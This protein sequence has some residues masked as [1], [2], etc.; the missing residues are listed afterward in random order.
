MTPKWGPR[1]SPERSRK[2]CLKKHGKVKL[3]NYTLCFVHVGHP[4][5]S[6]I[7]ESLWHQKS[8]KTTSK[9][10][11]VKKHQQ[12]RQKVKQN[13]PKEN[14]GTRLVSPFSCR[15]APFRSRWVSVVPFG[16]SGRSKTPKWPPK[17]SPGHP[18]ST[19]NTKSYPTRRHTHTQTSLNN[20]IALVP[21]CCF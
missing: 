19:K 9:N 17:W 3:D 11:T 21:P 16:A 14:F 20:K 10:D 6:L 2:P 7:V 18:K 1:G 4:Q 5:K 13:I 15:I 12:I 8:T